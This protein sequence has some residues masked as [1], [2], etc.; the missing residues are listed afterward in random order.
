MNRFAKD[1]LAHYGVGIADGAPGRGSGRYPKGSGENPYQRP[2]DFLDRIEKL[3]SQGKSQKEIA[4]I[5]GMS[6]TQLRAHESLAKSERRAALVA[7][8]KELREQGMSLNAIA[9]EMGYKND[10]SV[11]SLLNENSE[12]KMN[13]AM[14][15]AMTLKALVEEKGMID[16]G[17]GA[18]RELGIS[19]EKMRAALAILEAEGYPVY[20]GGIP[21]ITNAG[22]Q[23][24]VKVLCPPGTEHKDIY[25]FDQIHSVTDYA[26][27]DDGETFHKFRYP[28]SLDSKRLSICY[29]EDGGV[30]KDG[31]I[32]LRRGCKD[33]SLGDANYSQVRILVDG[34]H[35]LKG[36]AVYSDD[37]P[38]GVD[39]RFNTNKH[40]GT[41]ALGPKDNTVLKQIKT[42]DPSNPFGSLIMPK[43]QSDWVDE[44]G[45]KHLSLI[46]KRADEGDWTNW[47]NGLPS[48][49]LSKQPLKMINSQLGLAT[50]DK[51]AEFDEICSLTNPT[52]K[53]YFLHSFAEDCDSAAVHLQA[54]SLPRQRYQVILPMPSLKDNETY[55]PNFKDGEKLA[56]IRFPHGGTFEIPIV[57]VNN[58]HED[59]KKMIGT[60]PKD[61]ITI[62]SKVAARLSGADFDGDTVMVIPLKGA[63]VLSTP[64]L[65]GLKDFDAKMEYGGKPAGSF[66]RMTKQGTQTEMGKISNLITDM[67]LKGANEE[68][69][70]RAVKHSM[71]VIDAEK[72][73]LDYKQSEKD[74]RI[75]E[76][77]DKYQNGGGASTLIS[78]AKS[79]THIPKTKGSP[80]VDLNTGEVY[81]NLANE[82]YTDK[83]GNLVQR[84]QKSTKMADTKDAYTLSS[85][86]LQENAYADYANSMKSLANQAR[87]EELSTGNL[88][89]SSTARSAYKNEYD[90][91]M[92]QLNESAKNAP[93]ERQAQVIANSKVASIK[94]DN[95]DL[96]KEDIK[97]ISQQ[98][99]T[100]A[101]HQVGAQRKPITINDR[102]WEAIQ[103]GAVSENQLKQILRY[104]DADGLRQRAMPRATTQL[105]DAKVNKIK[106]MQN[107]GYTTQQIAEA[108][109]VSASTIRKYV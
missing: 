53:K 29:A 80:K 94:A 24:N 45:N 82:F 58:K 22:K 4:D 18:N 107:S 91:L 34:T 72:H 69:L 10:S 109:D 99:L 60:T 37:L 95:P 26:S 48:Q 54:A 71:V 98:A 102:E 51:R 1:I 3:K 73:G 93:R 44:D 14:Q 46:N 86:T 30:E 32:E 38:D 39:V 66:T 13:Q 96:S 28:E 97:K 62:N 16:V 12:Y 108:L 87:K 6:T 40:K 63:K 52:L 15:T 88:A 83:K 7:R 105:S 56:L 50:A 49:F 42:D 84:T 64:A 106:A 103:A 43:G 101:R 70:A 41:P 67:T 27:T 9:K 33:L 21:Q 59:S 81:Y 36:M 75:Q 104:A 55:A 17:V 11:R 2:K 89:Y 5:L 61:A 23:T 20:G 74:N 25:N 76:L 78:Q 65:E 100:D 90:H 57:T 8:A 31:L 19:Q 47:R 92:A 77:K 35:Y 79:E 68:E 85:G